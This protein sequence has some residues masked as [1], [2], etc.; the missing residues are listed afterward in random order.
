MDSKIVAKFWFASYR[1]GIHVENLEILLISC[2][3][4]SIDAVTSF[5]LF[6]QWL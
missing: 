1:V 6:G 4:P 5:T 3:Q 2:I